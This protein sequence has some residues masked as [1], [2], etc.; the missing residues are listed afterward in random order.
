MVCASAGSGKTY[1]LAKR[2]LNLVGSGAD[3]SKI[4]TLTFTN[5]AAGEM[6]ERIIQYAYRLV[7]DQSYVKEFESS[8]NQFY[9]DKKKSINDHLILK[10][11]YSALQTAKLIIQNQ[12]NLLISTIDAIN[13]QWLKRFYKNFENNFDFKLISDNFKIC[14]KA[15]LDHLKDK[16]WQKLFNES[17]QDLNASKDSLS[18]HII[19]RIYTHSQ[20]SIT[21]KDLSGWIKQ[22]D[23]FRTVMQTS[24]DYN[25]PYDLSFG[26]KKLFF[27]KKLDYL[28]LCKELI[29][30]Q[31][32]S[33]DSAR[34]DYHL[35]EINP[36]INDKD[37]NHH[38]NHHDNFNNIHSLQTDNY[39]FELFM[40][41]LQKLVIDTSTLMIKID[42]KKKQTLNQLLAKIR[43][44]KSLTDLSDTKFLT[45]EAKISKNFITKKFRQDIAIDNLIEKIQNLINN[46]LNYLIAKS[47]NELSSDISILYQRYQNNLNK[48]K[49]DAQV[50]D[51]DDISMGVYR[52]FHPH[53]SNSYLCLFNI[54]ESLSHVLVDELQDTSLLQWQIIENISSELLSSY[55]EHDNIQKTV[56]FVGDEKQSLYG[57][58]GAF[59]LVMD[60]ARNFIKKRNCL[61]ASLNV[62]YRSCKTISDYIT[63]VFKLIKLRNFSAQISAGD[64]A[65]SDSG[66]DSKNSQNELFIKDLA[67]IDILP[68]ATYEDVKN[69]TLLKNLLTD[70]GADIKFHCDLPVK[71][72]ALLVAK[73]IKSVLDN[74]NQYP[75]IDKNSQLRAIKISD[76]AILYRDRN[77]LEY[78]L[79]ALQLYNISYNQPENHDFYQTRSVLDLIA[80][81][82]FVLYPTDMVSC[83]T[84]LK[85]CIVGLDDKLIYSLIDDNAKIF[86]K[87]NNNNIPV[88]LC[89]LI[90]DKLE[91]GKKNEVISKNYQKKP[92]KSE[93]KKK[94]KNKNKNQDQ[95]KYNKFFDNDYDLINGQITKIKLIIDFM[96]NHNQSF[97]TEFIKLLDCLDIKK[98][99][100]YYQSY[101]EAIKSI[102]YYDQFK[103][104][105]SEFYLSKSNNKY[106][107]LK[108][109]ENHELDLD[110]LVDE[111]L[112][113]YIEGVNILTI[114][115][116]KGL[117]FPMV[118]VCEVSRSWLQKK[119]KT[120]WLD[121]YNI[122]FKNFKNQNIKNTDLNIISDQDLKLNS[123]V[124]YKYKSN[125]KYLSGFKN[126]EDELWQKKLIEYKKDSQRLL[127]VALTRASQ[128][129]VVSS[130]DD[131]VKN[132]ID[133][134]KKA[135]K[136]RKL[137]NDTKDNNQLDFYSY[138]SQAINKLKDFS[139]SKPGLKNLKYSEFDDL[140]QPFCY[141]YLSFS[142][143]VL[144]KYRNSAN[145]F[146]T[147]DKQKNDHLSDYLNI[148]L[149]CLVPSSFCDDNHLDLDFFDNHPS[150][151]QDKD[152]ISLLKEDKTSIYGN[153]VH[154]ILELSVEQNQFVLPVFEELA[155]KYFQKYALH[156]FQ[157]NFADL[158]KIISKAIDE[159]KA[160]F[161][162]VKKKLTNCEYF[163]CEQQ[164]YSKKH[165]NFSISAYDKDK[166]LSSE[167]QDTDNLANVYI[168]DLIIKFKDRVEI[169]DYKTISIHS[170]SKD[171][172]NLLIQKKQYDDQ[173]QNYHNLVKD[174]FESDGK[175]HIKI[176]CYILFTKKN[177]LHPISLKSI[178]P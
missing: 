125:Q 156:N 93:N 5:K 119:Q 116:A 173:L 111:N 85:S 42:A 92:N 47:L 20:C 36:Y 138:L 73:K 139:S 114:H 19:S 118:I 76:I 148:H 9:L 10:K 109:L 147:V 120:I 24:S 79:Q 2:F 50:L 78:F 12:D 127:Y 31:D 32:T 81:L 49:F 130:H 137:T 142:S 168:P 62:S 154:R 90:I 77:N 13:F 132:S 61:E 163:L 30:I 89:Q 164:F 60:L 35:N 52:L 58:R 6:K 56:F 169:I 113:S 167:L 48:L 33:Y 17:T 176:K 100:I 126:I 43:T 141:D 41:I 37:K 83:L 57:F 106:T 22:L 86:Q 112:S 178:N 162:L 158:K 3:P 26:N 134:N 165:N 67:Q 69:E 103:N 74:A 122:D 160:C 161:D 71:L 159:A 143:N 14:S 110:S 39:L 108:A 55:S 88:H 68:K 44:C 8:I 34:L 45:S 144:V 175:N 145:E 150:L 117:E 66:S 21:S 107:L 97:C 87:N 99:Y 94:N 23:R 133:S 54:T 91:N 140:M 25:K 96:S 172:L 46:Y 98:N 53:N 84:V 7:S 38:H 15:E 104:L 16:A 29:K 123:L 135:K 28:K 72:E 70:T 152:I 174:V 63:N 11:P 27:Q 101:P 128:Y 80:L 171:D 129:L 75:V 64:I 151:D 65:Y 170:T 121:F 177:I 131:A 51:Y 95:L 115:K 105:V 136:E 149:N 146:K 40:I 124:L 59:Y 1:N 166:K 153:I 82:R 4:L 157:K 18:K 155:D 102:D